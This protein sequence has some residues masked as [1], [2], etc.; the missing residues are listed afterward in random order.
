MV[1]VPGKVTMDLNTPYCTSVRARSN[2]VSQFGRANLVSRD[3][4]AP[5]AGH[6]EL[7]RDP[8]D[9]GLDLEGLPDLGLS[10]AGAGG[11]QAI[12][13]VWGGLP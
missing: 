6:E 12:A 7:D 10:A 11:E 3:R 1:W 4:V 2:L 5:P 13:H 8:L 9:D